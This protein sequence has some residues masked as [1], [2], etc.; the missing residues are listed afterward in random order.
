[1][2]KVVLAKPNFGYE[3]CCYNESVLG[4]GTRVII[5]EGLS[6]RF[7]QKGKV[8]LSGYGPKDFKISGKNIPG[9]KTSLFKNGL[10]DVFLFLFKN[11]GSYLVKL[12]EHKLSL[13]PGVS[14][15]RVEQFKTLS[16]SIFFR[17]DIDGLDITQFAENQKSSCGDAWPT[18]S[19]FNGLAADFF[20]AYLGC[21]PEYYVKNY[22][23][24]R[25]KLVVFE[26]SK[27]ANPEIHAIEKFMTEAYTA[28]GFK[29]KVTC[30]GV[31]D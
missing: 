17:I 27:D 18:V 13:G 12:I 3:G 4:K 19:Q 30:V 22:L 6:F 8:L 1:M 11:K 24:E 2:N 21:H 25:K 15:E 5:P 20:D 10:E 26:H 23:E 29:A 9:L 28:N 16:F 14:E 7:Q 31:F